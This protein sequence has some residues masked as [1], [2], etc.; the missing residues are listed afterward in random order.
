MHVLSSVRYVLVPLCLGP[1][2]SREVGVV[3]SRYQCLAKT[4]NILQYNV[5]GVVLPSRL[6]RSTL[7]QDPSA[8]GFLNYSTT[9]FRITFIFPLDNIGRALVKLALSLILQH[10]DSSIRFRSFAISSGVVLQHPPTIIDFHNLLSLALLT[11]ANICSS[12]G[13]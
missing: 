9:P 12:Q 1:L 4:I 8:K 3:Q 6:Y 7:K 10:Y 13:T 5:S 11:I 2:M